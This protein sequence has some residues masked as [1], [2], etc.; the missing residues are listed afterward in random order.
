[1]KPVSSA[2]ADWYSSTLAILRI[3][4]F[5]KNQSAS[6]VEIGPEIDSIK[7]IERF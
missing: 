4:R 6:S 1:L 3:S 5:K 7:L 2:E